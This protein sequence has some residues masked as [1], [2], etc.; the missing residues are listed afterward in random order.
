MPTL[1]LDL[2]PEN[3]M[4][5]ETLKGIRRTTNPFPD[6]QDLARQFIGLSPTALIMGE[7]AFRILL[8]KVSAGEKYRS[9]CRIS[10]CADEI[11]ATYSGSPIFNTSEIDTDAAYFV[12]FGMKEDPE[13]GT[14]KYYPSVVI[15][16]GTIANTEAPFAYVEK[17]WEFITDR[18]AEHQ[19]S[20]STGDLVLTHNQIQYVCPSLTDAEALGL[21]TMHLMKANRKQLKELGLE[22]WIYA[23]YKAEKTAY[24][25]S[26]FRS[27]RPLKTSQD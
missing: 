26:L 5:I 6:A 27:P 11:Q 18:M 14:N 19:T 13:T 7:N 9:F 21:L 10:A 24:Q 1:P 3:I 2:I 25:I 16:L 4:G 8:H 15:Q 20:G 23:G 12:Y 22:D 17:F